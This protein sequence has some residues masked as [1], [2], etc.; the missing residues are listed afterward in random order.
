MDLVGI[1]WVMV[2]RVS[3]LLGLKSR[4]LLPT[5]TLSPHPSCS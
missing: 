4:M 1:V 2:S 5:H 3:Y